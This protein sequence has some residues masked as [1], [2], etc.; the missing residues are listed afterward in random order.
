MSQL[1]EYRNSSAQMRYQHGLPRP[2]L[3]WLNEHMKLVQILWGLPSVRTSATRL[4]RSPALKG[5]FII[6]TP[7][8]TRLAEVR[9]AAQLLLEEVWS[10]SLLVPIKEAA[11]EYL[12]RFADVSIPRKRLRL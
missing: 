3:L 1:L 12:R 5:P 10:I 9:P 8:A 2:T 4:P 7:K 11:S 6:L